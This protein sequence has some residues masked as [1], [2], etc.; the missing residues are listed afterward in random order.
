MTKL[1][2]VLLCALL[3]VLTVYGQDKANKTLKADTTKTLKTVTIKAY[4]SDQP[5][6]SLPASVTVL[7]APQLKLQADNSLVPAMNTVPGVKMEE[8]SPGSYRLSIRGSLLRSPFGVRDVKVYFDEIP[9]TD[10]GGNTYLNAIDINSLGSLEIL[11]GPDGSLFGANSGGVVILRPAGSA[12]DSNYVKLGLNGGSYGLVHQNAA[13]QNNTGNNQLNVSQAYQSYGGYRQHS[14]MQRSYFQLA[15]KYAISP[16]DQLKALALYSDLNYQTPGGLTLAQMQADPQSARLATKTVPGAIDQDISISTKALLGGL[17]NDARLSHN[18]KNVLAVYG[19]HVDFANPFITNYEQRNE[20]TYGLRTYFELNGGQTQYNWKVNLG[21][22]WQQTNSGINNYDNNKGDKGNPQT[23]D[24]INTNQHFIFGRYTADIATRLHIEGALSL[25]Y[26]D[27]DFK[28]LYPLNQ[29]GFTP[30]SFSA[31]LMPRLALSYQLTNNFIARASVSRGYS[32]PTTA[33]V[34]PTDNVINT[35]LQAQTGWNYE[36]G[37]RLRN[38]DETMFLDASVFY[39]RINNSIVRRLHP[40]ETEYYVNAGG[41]NQTGFE[42]S[43]TDWL[44]RQNH[45]QFIRGLQFNTAYTLSSYFFRNYSDA[46]TNYSSNPLTGVPHD[47]LVS[48]IQVKFPQSIYV[49]VQHNYT[50]SIPL[51][52][53]HNVFA[54]QYHLLQAKAGWTHPFTAKTKLEIYAGA[55]NL[56]NAHY[57]LGNDLNAVG[58]RYFNPSPLRNYFAGFNVVF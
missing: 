26:Y 1:Y 55:D 51:N 34:R 27:Y 42:L 23:Q 28:N 41:T 12:A 35:A 46:T 43:F 8:R 48:S 32:T 5:V 53:A 45:T 14:Y 18:L 15:D 40:D 50:A 22:E 29:A 58:N 9:L 38:T 54:P 16:N 17:V 7:G 6:L 37:L 21:L 13:I 20:N 44:I 2:P 30:R 25:N 52:D 33:E 24:K 4:L 56:L 11:K 49:F 36:T 3:P 57:S 39:Y 19:M 47:V 10:A 31:Q